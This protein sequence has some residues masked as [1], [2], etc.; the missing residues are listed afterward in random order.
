MFEAPSVAEVEAIVLDR[1]R[2]ETSD[3]ISSNRYHCIIVFDQPRTD[4]SDDISSKRYHRPHHHHDHQQ[5][6]V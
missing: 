6:A 3:D 5:C 1:P 2:T 4:T